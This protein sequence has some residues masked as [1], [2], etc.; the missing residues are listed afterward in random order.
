[1]SY[2]L[3]MRIFYIS[4]VV[5]FVMFVVSIILFFKLKILKAIGILTGTTAKKEIKNI[6]QKNKDSNLSQNQIT[7]TLSKKTVDN[8]KGNTEKLETT[9]LNNNAETIVLNNG[10]ETT[11][12][13]ADQNVFGN[14]TTVLGANQNNS[15][16]TVLQSNG[17]TNKLKSNTLQNKFKDKDVKQ[18]VVAFEVVD[19]ITF[20]HTSEIIA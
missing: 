4:G 5:A 12:L 9:V 15:E 17:I 1:M 16:T 18:K 8:E 6:R 14:E 19:E 10:N 2:D 7:E 11:V 13:G 20:I 3:Y